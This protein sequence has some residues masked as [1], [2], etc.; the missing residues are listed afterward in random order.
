MADPHEQTNDTM[1]PPGHDHG[2]HAPP[3]TPLDPAN[4]SLADALRLSFRILKLVMVALVVVFLFSGVT[5]VDQRQVVVLSRFG[6]LV[7]EPLGPGLHFAW[8]FPIDEKIEVDTSLR[9]MTVDAFWLRLSERDKTLPLSELRARSAGLDPARD[10]AL[11]TGDR[12][13]MHLLLNVEYSVGDRVRV[14]ADRV[15][16]AEQLSD[17]ILFVCNVP[18]EQEL[19]RSV[20]K[21]A[22]VAES[23]RTTTDVIWKNPRLVAQAVRDRAQNMLDAM[24]TGILLE[25]VAAEQSYFPLQA[26]R[27]FLHVSQAENRRRELIKEAESYRTERLVNVAGPAWEELD[28]LIEQLD[29]VED[30]AEHAEVIEQIGTILVTQ[31]TGESGAVI[32]R[33]QQQREDILE[34]MLAEAARFNAYLPEHQRDPQ[35]VRDRLR[36]QMLGDLLDEPGLVKWWMPPGPN[37]VI[38]SLSKDP[39]EIL[40]AERERMRQKTGEQ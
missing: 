6:R 3:E 2:E 20:I 22:T 31:A 16:P 19:L 1:A 32:R 8:P 11:L 33:A 39:E 34:Q 15:E 5:M 36:L 17:V 29:Q 35:L 4:Q 9:T 10:G 12:G 27:E 13:I 26:Q 14:R 23:A 7:G 24:E 25:K 38:L 37:R 28:R 21:D 40:Q 18:N 30:S